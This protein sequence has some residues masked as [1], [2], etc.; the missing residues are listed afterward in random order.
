ME[1][2]TQR[3]LEEG[4]EEGVSRRSVEEGGSRPMVEGVEQRR[5]VVE[6]VQCRRLEEVEEQEE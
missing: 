2:E 4:A 3:H 6:E 1:E 5:L